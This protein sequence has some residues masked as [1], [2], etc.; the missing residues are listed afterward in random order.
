MLAAANERYA[1]SQ[2]LV[3]E[4]TH[5]MIRC[6]LPGWAMNSGTK[7]P[8]MNT[9]HWQ[10]CYMEAYIQYIPDQNQAVNYQQT[11]W[12]AFWSWAAEGIGDYGFPGSGLTVPNCIEVDFLE[13]FG[14]A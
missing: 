1:E 9:G 8:P 14:H 3:G 10:R 2:A 6:S 7:L 11:G 4:G 13:Q 5:G 12:P